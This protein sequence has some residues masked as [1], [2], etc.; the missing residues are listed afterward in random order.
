M[1]I[2][3][4]EIEKSIEIKDG[5]KTHYFGIKILMILNLMF[6]ILNLYDVNKTRMEFK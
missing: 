1:K 3:Y 6:A 5:I 2:K 4:N